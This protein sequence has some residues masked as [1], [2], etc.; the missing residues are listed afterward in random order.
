MNDSMIKSLVLP[1]HYNRLAGCGYAIYGQFVE[2]NSIGNML[3]IPLPGPI[4]RWQMMI[5]KTG[6]PTPS[7]VIDT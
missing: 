3:G 4:S 7:A 5:A 6:N 2:V 1:L